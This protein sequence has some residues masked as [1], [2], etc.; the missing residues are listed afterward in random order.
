MNEIYL[1][2]R[3]ILDA[4]SR[5]YGDAWKQADEFRAQRK[6]LGAGRTGASCPW[7]G[8]MPSFPEAA[9]STPRKRPS[10]SV[11]WAPWRPGG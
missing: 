7:P 4:I 2:P 6:K 11:S 9:G 10:T 5:V 3:K 8:R 1:R